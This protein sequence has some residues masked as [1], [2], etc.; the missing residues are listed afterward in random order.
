LIRKASADEGIV[1]H[2]KEMKN[3]DIPRNQ[4]QFYM[5]LQ[6]AGWLTFELH[7]CSVWGSCNAD[8]SLTQKGVAESKAW[9]RAKD[10]TWEVL[11]ARAELVEITGI[12]SSEPTTANVEYTMRAVPTDSGKEL[13]LESTTPAA[14]SVPFKR[15]DD[16]WRIVRK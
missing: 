1:I 5:N 16:G 3:A 8:A 14:A 4:L 2:F 7:N 12:S 11:T 6:K 9:K 10:G 13:G 15:Y